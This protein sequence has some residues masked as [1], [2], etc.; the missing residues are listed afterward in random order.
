MPQRAKARSPKGWDFGVRAGRVQQAPSPP[1]RGL[2]ERVKLPSG[3]WSE[4]PA[5][6]SFDVFFVIT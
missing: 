2:V 4:A 3:V 1:A 5:A 6:K